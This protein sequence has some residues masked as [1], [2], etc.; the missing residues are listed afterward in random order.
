MNY[1]FSLHL[2]YSALSFFPR[3]IF[4]WYE[5]GRMSER[6]REEEKKLRVGDLRQ[7]CSPLKCRA[8]DDGH[9]APGHSDGATFSDS[10]EKTQKAQSQIASDKEG[11]SSRAIHRHS[12]CGEVLKKKKSDPKQK[13]LFLFRK[14][15][16]QF[17]EYIIEK[18][19]QA[20]GFCLAITINRWWLF[21]RLGHLVSS[22]P[23]INKRPLHDCIGHSGLETKPRLGVK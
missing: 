10:S 6:Q 17:F 22:Q 8:A 4:D 15:K 19:F 11:M 3:D 18:T 5:N 14:V 23:N 1:W 12:A 9:N 2:Q 21:H 16:L 13:L 20:F 7:V